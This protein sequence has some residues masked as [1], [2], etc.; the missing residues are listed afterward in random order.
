MKKEKKCDNSI[1]KR[2]K[3]D[4]K[5]CRNKREY[6]TSGCTYY[7]SVGGVIRIGNDH[8]E[9][10]GRPCASPLELSDDMKNKIRAKKS[11]KN[12]IENN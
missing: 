10:K 1:W 2:C 5:R 4:A 11:E 8:S 6:V 12:K 3:R 9:M 7:D